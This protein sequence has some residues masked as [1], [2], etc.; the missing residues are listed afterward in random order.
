M[1]ESAAATPPDACV[2]GRVRTGFVAAATVATR[3]ATTVRTFVNNSSKR[4][5]WA[6]FKAAGFVFSMI[7][8]S[9]SAERVL[10]LLK[11]VFGDLQDK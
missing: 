2:V 7:P 5:S 11:C 3:S 9:A 4:L 1:C 6:W 10:S 8:N